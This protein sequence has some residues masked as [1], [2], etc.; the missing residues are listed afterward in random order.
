MLVLPLKQDSPIVF[1]E[2][3]C[4]GTRHLTSEV[5]PEKA[6]APNTRRS[7]FNTT[8]VRE[9]ASL[10]KSIHTSCIVT[11][12]STISRLVFWELS[13]AVVIDVSPK[14]PIYVIVPFR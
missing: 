8:S 10:Q 12:K 2:E 7:L 1:N 3:S 13:S 6:L 14:S 9:A 4:S 5:H 11:E